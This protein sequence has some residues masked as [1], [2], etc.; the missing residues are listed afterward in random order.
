MVTYSIVCVK[1]GYQS[2]LP[3]FQAPS[4]SPQNLTVSAINARSVYLSWSPPPREHHNGVIRQFWINITEVDTGRRFQRTSVD[5][6][7]T[8][9]SLHPFYT[10]WFSVAAY[11]VSLGPFTEPSVLQMPQ[12][13]KVNVVFLL[14]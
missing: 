7:F 14:L 8:L 11:T 10:Y 13:G 5:T 12:D 2:L 6:S 4:S 9:P 3:L 1:K